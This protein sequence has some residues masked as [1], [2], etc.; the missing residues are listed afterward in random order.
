MVCYHN[1][2]IILTRIFFKPVV[3]EWYAEIYLAL[4]QV[5][6]CRPPPLSFAPIFMKDAHSA[7]S[8]DSDFYRVDSIYFFLIF[9][10]RVKVIFV[11]KTVNFRCIFTKT[12]KIKIEKL[13]FPSIQHIAHLPLK[14]KQNWGETFSLVVE[15]PERR[16]FFQ[17]FNSYTNQ[18]VFF[19]A[20]KIHI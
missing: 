17:E 12:R 6:I 10:F 7:E 5:R 19:R 16:L 14:P 2:L 20:W 18:C 15:K 13:I 1:N 9:N 11:L 8:N 3:S 4:S